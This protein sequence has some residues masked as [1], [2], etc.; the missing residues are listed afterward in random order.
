MRATEF[1]RAW[2]GWSAIACLELGERTGRL[3]V[4]YE[5]RQHLFFDLIG[6]VIAGIYVS[7][8][9][10]KIEHVMMRLQMISPD[11]V[12]WAFHR[13]EQIERITPLSH[14]LLERGVITSDQLAFARRQQMSDALRTIL[15]CDR[16]AVMFIP[17][18][19][20]TQKVEALIRFDDA[21]ATAFA[22]F[23]FDGHCFRERRA[24]V[25]RRHVDAGEH[26]VSFIRGA[27]ERLAPTRQAR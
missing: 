17:C 1:Q 27:A 3:A 24:A 16:D 8:R 14:I 15:L 2:D 23:P 22:G 9:R 19:V 7:D 25:M 21:V 10:L 20:P 5:Q 12:R 26:L 18:P 11:D 6:G 13:L 4:F